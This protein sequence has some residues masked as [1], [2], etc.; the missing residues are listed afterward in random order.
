MAVNFAILNFSLNFLTDVRLFLAVSNKSLLL[1]ISKLAK[2][3][4]KNFRPVDSMS[5]SLDYLS[6]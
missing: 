5:S 6:K 1:K 4:N 3:I 2:K